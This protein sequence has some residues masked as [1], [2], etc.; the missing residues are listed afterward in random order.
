MKSVR[1]TFLMPLLALTLFGGALWMLH[2]ALR[3][4]HYHDILRQLHSLSPLQILSAL[5]L[6]AL[7]YLIMTGYDRLATLYIEH[8][9]AAAKVALTS[10]ISYAFS[11]NIGLSL[12]A[13][14]SIRYRL[15]STWGLST[16]EI[17]RVIS[18][19]VATFWLG[20]CT[21]GGLAFVIEPLA[22][23]AVLD[24]P[25]GTVRPLG[26]FFLL[27]VAGYLIV[28]MIRKTP[29]LVAGWQFSL[30]KPRLALAQILVGTL[31]W[32]IAGSVLY[33]LL[34]PAT[35]LSLFHLLG[36]YLLAQIVS[37]ISHVPGGLGVFE[38]LILVSMPEVPLDTLA[39]IL[40]VYR[41]IYYLFPLAV[42][43]LLLGGIEFFRKR[44]LAGRIMRVAVRW[45]VALTPQLLAASTLAG[46]AI[47]LFSGAT[48][49]VPGRLHW[50]HAIVPLPVLEI[51]HFFGS[52]VGAGLLL[53]A[54]GLQRRLDAAYLLSAALLASG[55]L[56]SLLKGADYEEA[57]LLGLMLMALLPCRRH[58][59]RR[60]SL[61]NEPF[62]AGWS[63][64]I[65]LVMGCS[66]WLGFFVYKHV[67]YSHDLWWHFA[68]TGDA[69]RFL[70]ALVGTTTLLLLF[71]GAKLLRP[72]RQIPG[73]PRAAEIEKAKAVIATSV[74]TFAN[75]ALLGDKTLLFNDSGTAFIMYAVEGRSW[76]AL[77]DP[78]GGPRREQQELIWRFREVCE[79]A[80]GWPVF[81]EISHNTTYLYLDLGL[82]LIKLGEE[83]KVPLA[84]FSLEGKARSGLRYSHRRAEKEGC[85]FEI[86][87]TSKVSQLMPELQNI[88]D[89]WLSGKNTKEKGFSLG[90]FQPDYL[91][92]NPVAVV[93]YKG[94]LVAFA[95]VWL[96]AQQEEVSIDLMRFLP[97][98]PHA[99]MDY[100]FISLILWGKQQGY[101]WFNLG[102]APLAGLENRPHAPLWH[103]VGAMVYQ[104]G[105]HFYNFQGL[106][107][108][109]EKFDPIWEP[110]YL[111]SPGGM[112]LPRILTNIAT[113][114]SGGAQG[115]LGK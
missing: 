33:V 38:S 110:R 85:S 83:A 57:M 66:L 115:I 7:S 41:S 103:R 106:R 75:L 67:D 68:L 62:S 61:V 55:S 32:I 2:H 60:T 104:H 56:F 48:P 45:G 100:L 108:Y 20:V 79:R 63:L 4:F 37:L 5:A 70:R 105:E 98:A 87:D 107:A 25:L 17:A 13:A 69:P 109:K 35:S 44:A 12:L 31:D 58:F 15:Y 112:A 102:M 71:A 39:G 19:T 36:I 114:I 101:H 40:L 34:P 22:I 50:L 10:F 49:G 1:L 16:E 29:F 52:L 51:S 24:L 81:Y 9:L 91:R 73:L 93:R 42:A 95:N 47:L 80:E 65:L 96:G 23:P 64:M 54:W 14:G 77:G 3:A 8:P 18:F 86:I 111:A 82:T 28:I 90:F 27:L 30:P 78:I 59:Y 21:A 11:N 76:V 94:T 89:T 88:S 92:A 43:T 97:G 53:V 74:E 84:Q 46:G 72:L 6:T 26:L 99:T 113:L